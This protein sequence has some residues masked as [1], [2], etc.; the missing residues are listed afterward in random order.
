M[1]KKIGAVVALA[2]VLALTGCG[3]ARTGCARAEGTV[4]AGAVF[5]APRVP[6]IIPRVPSV[7]RPGIGS[8]PSYR[9]PHTPFVFPWVGH[10]N[11]CK[12]GRK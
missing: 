5:I 3:S 1:K 2:L 10:G 6:V 12:G 8:R 4:D 11:S 7:P 9:A